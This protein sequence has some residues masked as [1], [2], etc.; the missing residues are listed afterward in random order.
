MPLPPIDALQECLDFENF[1]SAQ[2]P[3]GYLNPGWRRQYRAGAVL[4]QRA[5]SG[6]DP[7]DP[8]WIITTDQSM[9]RGHNDIEE[10]VFVD[11]IRQVYDDLVRL[12]E[13]EPCGAARIAARSR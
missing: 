11:F 12:K 6:F 4:T 13:A 3:R 1:N 9:I 7:N 10:P 8:F 5:N 2:R